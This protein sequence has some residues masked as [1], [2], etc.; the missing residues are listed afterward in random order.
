MVSERVA[1]RTRRGPCQE[2]L[3][4]PDQN[5]AL[6]QALAWLSPPRVEDETEPFITEEDTL[7]DESQDE[8]VM[9]WP[10]GAKT[11]NHELE[12]GW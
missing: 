9:F 4:M 6:K 8:E 7:P 11:R 3:T 12:N 10:D 1:M 5:D 2:G